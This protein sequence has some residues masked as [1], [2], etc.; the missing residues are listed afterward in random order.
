MPDPRLDDWLAERL[1]IANFQPTQSG[2]DALHL[3]EQLAGRT[4]KYIPD[5]EI[6]V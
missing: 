4:D 5:Q 1:T 2:S 3:I 6:I